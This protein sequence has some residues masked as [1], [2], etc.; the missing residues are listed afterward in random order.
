MAAAAAAA[1]HDAAAPPLSPATTAVRVYAAL[2]PSAASAPYAA[3][4]CGS[5]S[6]VAAVVRAHA[7]AAC[8]R[9]RRAVRASAAVRS[10]RSVYSK[11]DALTRCW[12]LLPTAACARRSRRRRRSLRSCGRRR[13][14][15]WQPRRAFGSWRQKQKATRSRSW[16]SRGCACSATGSS[17]RA[18][19]SGRSWR[20]WTRRRSS[21]G[22]KTNWRTSR[23]SRCWRRRSRWEE[24]RGWRGAT[25]RPLTAADVC[26]GVPEE[27]EEAAA[28]GSDGPR[29]HA[30]G[31]EQVRSLVWSSV[32]WSYLLVC[33]GCC[34]Q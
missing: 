14:T 11:S 23:A 25:W 20:R 15:R 3:R 10:L 12:L 32:M 31:S 29:R 1:A 2:L 9:R 8:E 21:A 13:A 24:A 26:A 4:A 6:A 28:S 7:P 34:W 5:G 16:S 27:G 17:R 30:G 19:R 18:R 33:V 22:R